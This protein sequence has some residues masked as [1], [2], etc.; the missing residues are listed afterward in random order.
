MSD[1][2]NKN[3]A[4]PSDTRLHDP[5]QCQI[6]DA[7]S[8]DITDVL[9][10]LNSQ[11]QGLDL[12][13]ISARKATCQRNVLPRKS[14]KP[15]SLII[16]HQFLSPLVYILL[17][18]SLIS[19][20]ISEW[21]DAGFIFFV[22]ALN[23]SIG[24]YQEYSAQRSA[25]MLSS[26]MVNL[27]KVI[28][29][30]DSY[31]INTE[32][33]VPGDIV[34]LESGDKVPAD[35]RLIDTYNIEV[36]QSLLTGESDAI[37]KSAD[38]VHDIKCMLAD[39]VNMVFTGTHVNRGR[40]T[41]VVTAT[42][43]HT[44]L[45]H[46]AQTLTTSDTPP[47]LIQRMNRL[48][49]RIGIAVSVVVGL[50]L[51]I[52][53]TQ[54]MNI[55]EI[56]FMAVA[57][58]VSAIPEG[59]PVS[60]TIA[61]TIGSKR[62]VKN[63]VIVR[64]LVAI[65]SL[66]SCTC[67]ATD[68]TGTL[69]MNDLTASGISL[70][71][72]PPFNITGEGSTPNGIIETSQTQAAL[73]RDIMLP[74][75]LCNEAFLGHRNNTWSHHGDSV[76]VA[77]LVMAHKAG[78]TQATL[79]QQYPVI[80]T[81]PFEPELKYS[82]SLHKAEDGQNILFIKGA[83][84]ALTPLCSHMQTQAGIVEFDQQYVFDQMHKL[85]HQGYRVLALAS[86]ATNITALSS[87]HIPQTLIFQG[88]VSMT[89][90]LRPG[91]KKSIQSCKKAGIDV[92]MITGDHPVTAQIIAH[93]LD[94]STDQNDIITGAQL[95]DIPK[96]DTD[97]FDQII[98]KHHVFA[99]IEPQQKLDIVNSLIRQGHFVAVTGDGAN[100]APALHAAHVGVAMGKSGTDIARENADIIITDDN[101]SSIVAGITTG[102]SI[103]NN[104]RNVV[105]LLIS[106]GAAEVVLFLL[107][108]LFETPLPLLAVQ[109]LWLNLVTNGIQDVALAF[110][111]EEGNEMNRPPRSP[112]EPLF[113]RLMTERVI[114]SAITIGCLAFS[115]FYWLIEQGYTTDQARNST[116][117]LMVLFENVH[118]L[119]ART[120]QTSI[121]KKSLT[122][123]SF[124]IIGTLGAQLLHIVA[125]YT[126]GLSDI[127]R[128]HPVSPEHWLS[129][130]ILA[131]APLI[132]L[133]IHK[134][135]SR[136]RFTNPL[137][138]HFL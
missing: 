116:L 130:L 16:A 31:E 62:M 30:G 107:S 40:A 110:D 71:H 86:L 103:Y 27:C 84:E 89:D 29:N 57:L 42:G 112:R 92:R 87:E 34:S 115:V 33:L 4:K 47:P 22:L 121:F 95:K 51:A 109:L 70:P 25:D 28:R 98:H 23:A 3:L 91:V 66:G 94:I 119:S 85:A 120:E 52:A 48:V 58:S 82:A 102:R 93:T 11:P 50:M 6:V 64:R 80:E 134:T 53:V 72:T 127:L 60:V 137:D 56:F 128:V 123:N 108:L 21:V 9:K 105:F 63:N 37:S 79:Q 106:T 118:V 35:I 10:T 39:R 135:I 126:P 46:I 75:T 122:S 45:G 88:L 77:L 111:P 38:V 131:L 117:L 36:N 15:I 32:E 138:S 104:I 49:M 2:H 133:E 97:A 20:L 132:V 99:R 73:L 78:Y 124:L 5:S 114:I 125:M 19:I 90:P 101:F 44:E 17:G 100:D 13:T 67:I 83:L 113:N 54:H 96:D 1:H 14:K 65:E 74:A 43:A 7:Y 129:L 24:A 69:T 26:M 81:I 61:L 59:L 55:T 136:S 68:K 12:D 8:L 41:G 18:A 76:D